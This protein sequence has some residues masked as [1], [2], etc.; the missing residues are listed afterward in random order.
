MFLW[1]A[2][3]CVG[4][5]TDEDETCDVNGEGWCIGDSRYLSCVNGDYIY[6]ECAHDKRCTLNDK[7]KPECK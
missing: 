3:A 7:G 1:A 2:M 4:A 6:T 5:C